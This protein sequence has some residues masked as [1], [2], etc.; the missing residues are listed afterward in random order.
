MVNYTHMNHC[1]YGR[2][3]KFYGILFH[4]SDAALLLD[5]SGYELI[6]VA[7][8]HIDPAGEAF[9]GAFDDMLGTGTY[10]TSERASEHQR[11]RNQRGR[12]S[13]SVANAFDLAFE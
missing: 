10:F 4:G 1:N 9:R 6:P 11:F 3:G 8:K 7:T 5:R 12:R 13:S 2:S